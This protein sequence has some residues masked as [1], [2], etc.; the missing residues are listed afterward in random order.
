[1]VGSFDDISEIAW[2][3]S[4]MVFENP[5]E[6]SQVERLQRLRRRRRVATAGAADPLADQGAA[7][8]CDRHALLVDAQAVQGLHD[9]IPHPSGQDQPATCLSRPSS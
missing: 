5:E 2:E 9:Q 7:Q 6:K 8:L 1:M 3:R 4:I